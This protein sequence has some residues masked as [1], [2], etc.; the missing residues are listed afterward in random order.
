MPDIIISYFDLHN[1][2]LFIIIIGI[3]N[4]FI[5]SVCHDDEK[6]GEVKVKKCNISMFYIKINNF[7]EMCHFCSKKKEIFDLLTFFL[8]LF[9]KLVGS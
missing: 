8:C 6:G 5:C 9:Q 2:H 7:H 1:K 3:P 4:V